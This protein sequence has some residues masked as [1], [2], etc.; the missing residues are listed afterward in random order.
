MTQ[1]ITN[2]NWLHWKYPKLFSIIFFLLLTV[3]NMTLAYDKFLTLDPHPDLTNPKIP[4]ITHS[5]AIK[6][7]EAHNM[8]RISHLTR[9]LW[10]K[11]IVSD[12]ENSEAQH[13]T[14]NPGCFSYR[15]TPCSKF[16]M[17]TDFTITFYPNF[18]NMIWVLGS[19][20]AFNFQHDLKFKKTTTK[21]TY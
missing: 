19:S 17:I 20:E 5:M 10:N 12:T 18:L 3:L 9:F 14:V 8:T 13:L 1:N 7:C 11:I 16:T 4:D 2:L 6:L 15:W 21:I